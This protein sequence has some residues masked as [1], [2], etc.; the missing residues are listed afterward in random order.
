[1]RERVLDRDVLEV[2]PAAAAERPARGGQDERVDRVRC[3][4]LEPLEEGRVLGVDRQQ[5]ASAPLPRRQRELAG[6]DEALLVR[7]RQRDAALERPQRRADAG[8]ADDRVQDDVRLCG[9]EQFRDIAADLRVLD[10]V[11]AR[12]LRQVGGAG[13]ESAQS[14]SS[15]F[16][17][18]TSIACRPIEPVAPSS[19]IRFTCTVCPTPSAMTT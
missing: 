13:C 10:A 1:M 19:A 14:S 12:E 3:S 2:V 18:M 9:F 15:G 11:L 16:R 4:A 17:S 6:G 7:E 8:E 5:E